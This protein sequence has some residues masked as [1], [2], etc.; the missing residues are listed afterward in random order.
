MKNNRIIAFDIAKGIGIICVIIGHL[1][2]YTIEHMVFPFH[3][4]LFFFI[5]GWF[6]S[7]HQSHSKY[8]KNRAIKLLVP[9]CFTSICLIVLNII[10]SILYRRTATETLLSASKIF[11]NALYGAGVYTLKLP[12]GIGQIGA[13]WFLPAL[14]WA[15]AIVHWV[16]SKTKPWILQCLI[17]FIIFLIC[18][19][20]SDLI[21]LPTD[22]QSGGCAA[23]YVYLGWIIKQW[24]KNTH[25]TYYYDKYNISLLAL[26]IMAWVYAFT[27]TY[28]LNISCVFFPYF[29][30]SIIMSFLI[31]FGVLRLSRL[32]EKIGLLSRILSFYGR[33]SLMI[34]CFHLMELEYI[35]WMDIQGAMVN[36]GINAGF[37]LFLIS[38]LKLLICT[39]LVLLCTNMNCTRKLFYLK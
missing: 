26:G 1:K 36:L 9:Y 22:I 30:T 8:C 11:I 34:L 39:I 5:S 16:I 15:S 3:M 4:P 18:W 21:Y 24:F 2:D 23:L 33:Y 28:F 12:F 14:I 25:F 7:K 17:L 10:Q 29:P 13:I 32:I 19:K 6:L 37:Q 38:C 35:P 27:Q 20:S 31:I